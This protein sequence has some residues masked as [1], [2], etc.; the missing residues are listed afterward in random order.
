MVISRVVFDVELDELKLP[1]AQPDAGDHGA[2]VPERRERRAV[3]TM[4]AVVE[5]VRR[6][7]TQKPEQCAEC[8]AGRL[9]DQRL[10][11]AESPKHFEPLFLCD[12]GHSVPA[13]WYSIVHTAG[14]LAAPHT[15]QSN[16]LSGRSL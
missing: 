12:Y 6:A 14:D 11:E 10:G 8:P 9:P 16:G 7:P 2:T 3:R 13:T 1:V 5:E 15:P 4:R